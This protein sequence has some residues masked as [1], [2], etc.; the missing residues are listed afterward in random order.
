MFIIF[1]TRNLL[2]AQLPLKFERAK[3]SV[4]YEQS[5]KRS[6]W[7]TLSRQ[8]AF[9]VCQCFWVR[10]TWLWCWG[11]FTPPP[12]IPPQSD[13]GRRADSR[14]ALLQI[15][16][17]FPRVISELRRPIG[18]KFCTM[19]GDAF[20]CNKG[21]LITSELGGVT[22]GNFG[23]WRGSRLGCWGSR[24]A[25]TTFGGT[26]PLKFGRAKNFQNLVR[27]TTTFEFERKYLWNRWR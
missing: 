18:A 11:N 6:C 7:P 24:W 27:F 25:S 21:A 5:Y 23:T 26:A 4:Y 3:N 15:F 1:L 17:F 14:W 22:R 20:K 9:G 2:G 8:C 19:L 16:S 10:A 12:L 13:L